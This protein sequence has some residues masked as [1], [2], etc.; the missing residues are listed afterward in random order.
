MA[1]VC[2]ATFCFL[3]AYPQEMG[4]RLGKRKSCPQAR[5]VLRLTQD[6]EY[7]LLVGGV[8]VSVYCL[9]MNVT[10]PREY[11]SLPAGE[12]GNHAEIYSKR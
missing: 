11:L 8:N 2:A 9:G 3:S 12:E 5:S 1:A 10:E 7:A 6:G 4:N